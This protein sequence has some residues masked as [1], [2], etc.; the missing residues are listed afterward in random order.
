MR[1][2]SMKFIFP[3]HSYLEGR[4]MPLLWTLNIVVFALSQIA[5]YVGLI[6]QVKGTIAAK[7]IACAMTV[8]YFHCFVFAIT[9]SWKDLFRR[10]AFLLFHGINLITWYVIS[11]VFISLQW[12]YALA[13]CFILFQA[14]YILFLTK[15]ISARAPSSTTE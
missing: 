7:L 11:L 2:F 6:S 1:N 3:Q 4:A 13:A 10:T 9:L 8:F 15:K 5:V 12:E 14:L